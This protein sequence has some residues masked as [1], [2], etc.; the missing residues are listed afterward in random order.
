MNVNRE[1]R[2]LKDTALVHMGNTLRDFYSEAAVDNHSDYVYEK[3]VKHWKEISEQTGRSDLQYLLKL[4]NSDAHNFEIIRNNKNHL[5]VIVREC[6]HAQTFRK[7]NSGDLGE[8]LICR[9]DFAVVE[10]YNPGIKLTRPQT[11]MTG[12]CC[13][14]I[15]ELND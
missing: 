1:N 11:A 13:H 14:F 10:G 12:E 5:E 8:K 2:I 3:T 9:N 7:Y 6:V 15:F 4:F